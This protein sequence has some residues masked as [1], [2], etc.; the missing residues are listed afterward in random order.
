M[1]TDLGAA[2]ITLEGVERQLTKNETEK[3]RCIFRSDT[4]SAPADITV[5]TV[6][7]GKNGSV[8]SEKGVFTYTTASGAIFIGKIKAKYLSSMYGEKA[9]AEMTALKRAFDPALILGR[10]NIIPE[11]YLVSTA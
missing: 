2:G 4:D 9:F 7:K 3:D 1:E 11:Q 8:K 10:G 5:H 6:L